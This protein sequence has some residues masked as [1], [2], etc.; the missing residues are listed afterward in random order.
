[1]NTIFD[2]NVGDT[3]SSAALRPM[4]PVYQSRCDTSM[5]RVSHPGST[6]LPAVMPCMAVVQ[7]GHKAHAGNIFPS[8]LVCQMQAYLPETLFH[9]RP[10]Y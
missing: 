6:W 1:M 8:R 9:W 10:L 3:L 7:K 4:S 2:G 5:A